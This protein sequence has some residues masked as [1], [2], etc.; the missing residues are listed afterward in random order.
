MAIV[1]TKIKTNLKIKFLEQRSTK[2]RLVSL[3]KSPPTSPNHQIV[4]PEI[5]VINTS[6]H[7]S[8]RGG[9]THG[10]DTYTRHNTSQ[11]TPDWN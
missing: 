4:S 1:Y 8:S 11:N 6:R 3:T 5:E 9:C 10:N 7:N 2:N